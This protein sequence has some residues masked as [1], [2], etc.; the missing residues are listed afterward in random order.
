VIRIVVHPAMTGRGLGRRLLAELERAAQV[1]WID[2][3]GASFGATTELLEFWHA[4]GFVPAQIG[5]SRNAASGEHAVVV[6]RAISDRGERLLEDAGRRLTSSLPVWLAGPLREL[7]PEI[8]A[9]LIGA[10][11]APDSAECAT[12]ADSDDWCLELE[13]FVAGHRTLEASLPLLSALTRRYLADALSAG[14]IDRRESALLVAA[15]LQ[16]HP[17]TGLARRFE[18][19][20]REALLERLRKVCGRLLARLPA[21]R[22]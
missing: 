4:C 19:R 9:T 21:I 16:Y 7:D 10:R 11:P 18:A 15:V 13:S 6:L 14:R 5:T 3:R 2:L 20:G 12:H 1:E 8:A 22:P 17:L